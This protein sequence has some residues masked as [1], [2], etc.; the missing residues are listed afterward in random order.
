[1]DILGKCASHC[2]WTFKLIRLG[3]IRHN[4]R[5]SARDQFTS[6]TPIG[7]K[8]GTSPSSLHTALEGA[9]E[10]VNARWMCK[11]YMDSYIASNGSCFVVTW[12]VFKTPPLGGRSNIKPLGDRG[13]PNAHKQWWIVFCHVWG[14]AWIEIRWNSMSLRAQSHM[15]SHYTWGSVTTLLDFGGVL[16]WHVDTFFWALTILRSQLLARVW[17]GPKIRATSHTHKELRTVTIALQA[18]SLVEKGELVQ[19]HFTRRLRDQQSMWMQDGCKVY[20]GSYMASKGSCFMVTWSIFKNCLLEGGLTQNWETMALQ[21][22]T[23]V[24]LLC[25]NMREDPHE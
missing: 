4:T 18:L 23:T 16:G 15:T 5:P 21:M 9:T 3:P 10:Y 13:T 7:G 17:S 24:D 19:V 11:A 12:T 22:L 6:S 25:F 20:V 14:P 8:G 1:M 2:W